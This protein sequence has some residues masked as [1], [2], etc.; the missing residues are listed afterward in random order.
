MVSRLACITKFAVFSVGA[1]LFMAV[2]AA[3]VN[4]K[5]GVGEHK[6]CVSVKPDSSGKK[7]IA[8]NHNDDDGLFGY[9]FAV[10]SETVK[11]ICEDGT[12]TNIT[13]EFKDSPCAEGTS[14]SGSTATC[15]INVNLAK[16]WHKYE[17]TTQDGTYDDP[18]VIVDNQ[19]TVPPGLEKK[20]VKAKSKSSED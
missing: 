11:W 13:I 10:P 8:Y 16:K 9:V 17:I 19:V 12:C 3:G 6:I 4:C 1:I 14:V 18:H 7:R 2:D 20:K 5:N 15:T